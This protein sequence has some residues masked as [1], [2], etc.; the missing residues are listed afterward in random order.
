MYSSTVLLFC[1]LG[2]WWGW[3]VIATPRPLYHRDRNGTDYIRGWMGPRADLDGCGKSRLTR[4]TSPN[5]P[6]RSK[7]LY[8]QCCPGP[9]SQISVSKIC[10]A[11]SGPVSDCS[12]NTS[13]LPCHF[14]N[15]VSWS[16]AYLS[17]TLYVYNL[18]N[19]QR[20][21]AAHIYLPAVTRNVAK[22]EAS[23]KH[24]DLWTVI[25]EV[26]TTTDWLK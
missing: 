11:L 19:W 15:N 4:I 24:C 2:A 7:S 12:R 22:E 10:G 25:H 8:R 3:V 18:G 6:A 14:S 5:R 23:R 16:F 26:F 13:F 1:S 20:I 17:L 21:G 9:G